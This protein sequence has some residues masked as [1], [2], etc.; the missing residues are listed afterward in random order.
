M[1][2]IGQVLMAVAG[3]G[4]G[5]A[6]SASPL[7]LNSGGTT[8]TFT[9]ATVTAIPSGGSGNYSYAWS[10]AETDGFHGFDINAPASAA[11]TVDIGSILGG[12]FCQATLLCVVTDTDTAATAQVLVP[13]THQDMRQPV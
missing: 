6:V 3:S 1:S 8:A 5:L 7:S 11:T 10:V 13:I 12:D 9:T 4:A 2:G